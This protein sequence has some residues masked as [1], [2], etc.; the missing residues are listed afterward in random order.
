MEGEYLGALQDFYFNG[1]ASMSDEEF[2]NLKEELMWEGSS[3]VIMDSDEQ[4]FLEAT[5]AYFAGKP[6]LSDADFDALKQRLMEKGSKIA[7]A[8]PRCSLRSQKVYSDLSVDYLKLTAINLPAALLILG[9]F[10]VLDDVTGWNIT[11]AIELPEPIGTV[12]LWAVIFPTIYI[13][14]DALTKV[15]L[16]DALIL[17]GQCTNCEQQVNVFF[18][19][20]LGVEGNKVSDGETEV[21]CETCKVKLSADPIKRRLVELPQKAK[22]KKAKAKAR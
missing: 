14:T 17:K 20:I 7:L 13:L 2:D 19:D 21:M 4:R 12:V 16:K 1:T 11:K 10:F 9:G 15:V 6:V 5:E 22:K 3:V 18:G 8:G